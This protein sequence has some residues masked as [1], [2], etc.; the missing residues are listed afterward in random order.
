MK[1]YIILSILAT[2]FFTSCECEELPIIDPIM[3]DPF[4]ANISANQDVVIIGFNKPIDTSS[5][6]LNSTL[7]LETTNPLSVDYYFDSDQDSIIIIT[8][9]I[10]CGNNQIC[11]LK[12]QLKSGASGILSLSG[13]TLDGDRDGTDGGDFDESVFFNSCFD[14][15]PSL[16]IDSPLNGTDQYATFS[17]FFPLQPI[18]VNYTFSEEVDVSTVQFQETFFLTY[19]GTEFINYEPLGWSSDNKTFSFMVFLDNVLEY[20][21]IEVTFVGTDQGDGVV[22]SIDGYVLDGDAD[23]FPGGDY[24]SNIIYEII[25]QVE[26]PFSAPGS[27]NSAPIT[28]DSMSGKFRLDII[29]N[30]D[31]NQSINVAE[32]FILEQDIYGTLE[33]VPL[34]SDPVWLNSRHLV[35]YTEEDASTFMNPPCCDFNLTIL[36]ENSDGLGLVKDLQGNLLD[37]DYD[38]FW[39]GD[40]FVYLYYF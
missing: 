1:N 17:T 11:D 24:S 35:L 28:L 40:Y 19:G 27:P 4:I 29:F 7:F 36:P 10:N 20:E 16:L 3:V 5:V 13:Q 30:K 6:S 8:C 32:A 18:T 22:K 12:I 39:G 31:M 9:S 33:N 38:D 25:P 26:S 34:N 21:P 23:G 15:G 14:P 2:I 37:G